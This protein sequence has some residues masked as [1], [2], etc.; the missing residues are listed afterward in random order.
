[1]RNLLSVLKC[2]CGLVPKE[3]DGIS[4]MVFSFPL[5]CCGVSGQHRCVLSRRVRAAIR[6]AATIECRDDKH[7]TQLTVGV[8]L[9]NNVIICSRKSHTISSMTR[10]TRSSPAISKSEFVIVPFGLLSDFTFLVMS[11]GHCKRTTMEGHSLFS[12]SMTPLNPNDDASH[13]PM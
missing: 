11:S 7:V 12:P 4:V 10:S 3:R 2:H 9:L 8:L 1:M 6:F 13:I 5:V